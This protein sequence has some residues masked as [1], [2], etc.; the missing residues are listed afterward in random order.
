MK[1]FELVQCAQLNNPHSASQ[2]GS[3][4]YHQLSHRTSEKGPTVRGKWFESERCLFHECTFDWLLIKSWDCLIVV[5]FFLH[6]CIALFGIY[7]LKKKKKAVSHTQVV[8]WNYS[9]ILNPTTVLWVVNVIK[10]DSL[11]FCVCVHVCV[12]FFFFEVEVFVTR[13]EGRWRFGPCQRGQMLESFWRIRFL[14]AM[15]NMFQS[16][17]SNEEY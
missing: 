11:C 6:Q 16:E 5:I 8:L 12:I 15:M 4:F 7:L 14:D 10:N 17:V 9:S 1:H 13:K 3:T 2:N